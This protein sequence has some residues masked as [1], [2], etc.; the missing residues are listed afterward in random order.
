MSV[1]NSTGLLETFPSKQIPADPFYTQNLPFPSMHLSS[2]ILHDS[3]NYMKQ[4]PVFSKFWFNVMLLIGHATFLKVH[5]WK[6]ADI[7]SHI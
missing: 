1:A 5:G 4:P 3:R 7:A 6:S 2:R